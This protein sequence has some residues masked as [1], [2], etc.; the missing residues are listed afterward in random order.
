MSVGNANDA[1]SARDDN[2]TT[3]SSQEQTARIRLAAILDSSMDAI[4][5]KDMDGNVTDWSRGAE[6]I[7]GYAAA[8]MVGTSIRRLIPADRHEENDHI[9]ERIR[10]G[11]RALYVETQRQTK[12]GELIDVSVTV[13]P[14]R[15]CAGN[16]VGVSDITRDITARKELERL[17]RLHAASS[18]LNQAIVRTPS[19]DELFQK[20][21]RILVEHGGFHMAWIGWHDPATRQLVPLAVWGDEHNYIRS[22]EVCAD[23]QPEGRGP[24]GV[25]FREGR[26]CIWNDLHDNPASL[27]W[28]LELSRRGLNAAAAFPLRLKNEVC[29]TLT[30]YSHEPWFFQDK[31]IGLLNGAA[32]D[33]SFALDHFAQQEARTQLEIVV[34]NE[35]LFADTVIESMPGILYLYDEQGRFLRWNRN[36]QTV[37]GYSDDE[38]ARMRPLEFFSNE[39]QESLRCRIAE[40]FSNGQSTVEAD[41]VAKDGSATP[42]FFTGKRIAFNGATCLVGVGVDVSDLKLAEELLRKSEERYRTLFEYAPYGIIIA[43][44][45]S[46]YV[47]ANDCACRLLGFTREDLI[48]R[49]SS[50]SVIPEESAYIEP[51][52]KLIKSK[53]HYHR[54]GRLRRKDGSVFPSDVIATLMP[55]G[56]ILAM[57]RDITERKQAESA[58]REAEQ[59]FHTMFAEAPVGMVLVDPADASFVDFNE[60]AARQLGYTLQEFSGLKV[61]DIEAHESPEQVRQHIEQIIR[62]GEDHF[63]TQHVTKTR[64][65]RDVLV[66]GLTIELG[67]RPLFQCVFLDITDR[68]RAESALRKLNETLEFEVAAR[69]GELQAA[70]VRAEAADRIKSAFLAT[71]S[72]ELRTPLNS[73]I[74]FTGIVLQGLAGPLNAEQ[75]KQLGMVRTSARHLL[76]LI[77]DVLDLSKI[78]AGQLEVRA[79]PFDL[80]DSLERVAALV[81]PL[82]DKKG[83]ALSIVAPPALGE[84]VSDRRRVEQLLLNL[85]NNSIKFTEHGR[86]T[87]AAELVADYKPPL[88]QTCRPAVCLRVT[89]TG[90]GIRPADLATLF[91]PFRQIDTGISRRHEGTGLGL[92][93]C[94]RLATLL[95]GEISA[96]SE[97]SQGSEFSVIIPMDGTAIAS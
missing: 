81:R 58:L 12:G 57:F 83:L 11:E 43:A 56:N 46:R 68:K 19:R 24:T 74:G 86:V 61:S 22:I 53:A 17:T 66:T 18:Q 35:R 87:I 90:I 21:C 7:F 95:S 32:D 75:T 45:D 3:A 52:L 65:I 50:D 14:L 70:L 73:I 92:A 79:E 10:Q 39:Q 1:S 23:D 72:H 64:E 59:R 69:T 36:F 62:T 67:G 15:D 20:V 29:G 25:A 6:T 4:I 96:R 80:R 13:T 84:M 55:D 16:V 63:E 5:V 85:V 37:S 76:D 44:A 91:Q 34:R 48:G 60:Q 40:V 54:E 41:F 93:I 30:V 8:E 82:A 78:E 26:P 33:V 71:M 38:I 42:Y 28:R 2:V 31:E 94:R 51:A 77:N 47:D 97:W 9:L 89:D 49:H 88:A 27:P